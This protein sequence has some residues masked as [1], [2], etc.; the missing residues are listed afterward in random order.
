M[1]VAARV[2]ASQCAS[3]QQNKRSRTTYAHSTPTSYSNSDDGAQATISCESSTEEVIVLDTT[4]L[5][6]RGESATSITCPKHQ[7]ST[8]AL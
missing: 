1:R 6:S 4:G 7:L 5:G 8:T 2:L 3:P